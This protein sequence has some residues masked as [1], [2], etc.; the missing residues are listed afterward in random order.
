MPFA[1]TWMGLEMIIPN[2][3]SQIKA[4]IIQY[5]LYVESNKNDT[6]E[7]SPKTETDSNILKSSLWLPKK[8]H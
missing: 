7:Y 1:I 5:H 2:E 8:T 6:K 3:I 4:I